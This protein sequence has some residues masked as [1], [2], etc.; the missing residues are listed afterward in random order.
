MEHAVAGFAWP[1][2][3]ARGLV[4]FAM[5]G[6]LTLFLYPLSWLVRQ[7]VPLDEAELAVGFTAF[8]GAHVIN[9]PHFS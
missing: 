5:V 6:G 9:D 1:R 3:R 4:E 7:V 2:L 8:W